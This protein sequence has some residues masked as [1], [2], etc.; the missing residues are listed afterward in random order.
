M[1][2]LLAR[3]RGDQYHAVR[4]GDQR[5]GSVP[6][7]WFA[8][9]SACGKRFQNPLSI[10]SSFADQSEPREFSEYKD[11]SG[12]EPCLGHDGKMCYPVCPRCV[13]IVEKEESDDHL[14]EQGG[15]GGTR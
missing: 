13:K 8:Y 10:H 14:A 3:S 2:Y 6:R 11:V 12:P 9:R 4:E 1:R 15:L 5:Q 7:I